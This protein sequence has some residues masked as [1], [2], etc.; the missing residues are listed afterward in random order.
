MTDPTPEQAKRKEALEYALR[1][2]NE[3]ATVVETAQEI[4]DYLNEDTE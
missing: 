1:A 4:Y 3:D 2:T